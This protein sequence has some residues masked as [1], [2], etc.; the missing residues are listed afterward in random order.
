[1]NLIDLSGAIKSKFKAHG[2]IV[3]GQETSGIVRDV[4]AFGE[5]DRP[6]SWRVV[7]VG[8]DGRVQISR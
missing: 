4:V 3:N 5:A 2:G 7:S 6:E 1:L 8:Y